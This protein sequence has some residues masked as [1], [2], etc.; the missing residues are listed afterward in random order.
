[1][2][3]D[4]PSWIEEL[5]G[6]QCVE[7]LSGAEFGRVAV[8]V[9]A[10]PAIFPVVYRW[11]DGEIM[12]LTGA[13]TKLSAALTG[14]VVAFEVD[15]LEPAAR[16]GWS[17]HVVGV[18]RAMGAPATGVA[19]EFGRLPWATTTAQLAVIRPERIT[20]RRLVPAIKDAPN[21]RGAFA[22]VIPLRARTGP[23]IPTDLRGQANLPE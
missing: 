7:L 19:A 22:S 11:I 5:D 14:T 10:L 2:S 23:E 13:G 20:G 4:S 15:Q 12:F 3:P 8:T 6:R 1:V 21:A 16:G 18:A 9:H 17:V